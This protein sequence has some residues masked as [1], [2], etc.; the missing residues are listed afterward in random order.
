MSDAVKGSETA[1]ETGCERCE[2]ELKECFVPFRVGTEADVLWALVF[3][4]CGRK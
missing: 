4:N 3:L 1:R 2:A